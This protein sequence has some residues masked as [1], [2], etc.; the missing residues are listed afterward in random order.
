LGWQCHDAYVTASD[1]VSSSDSAGSS[2]PPRSPDL[3]VGIGNAL[4]GLDPTGASGSGLARTI[5]LGP[6]HP[7][8]HGV[9]RIRLWLD[10]DRITRAEPIVGLLH[11]GA[12]KL[13]EARD[14]RQIM[15]LSNRHDWHG[16]FTSELGVALALEEMLGIDVPV[17][18]TWIRTLLC[19]ITRMLSH[20]LF[21]GAFPWPD[22]DAD[23]PAVTTYAQREALQRVL[24][25]I[26]GGRMHV[27]FACVGGVKA[28]APEGWLSSVVAA[29]DSVRSAMPELA[30]LI[31]DERFV[32]LTRGVGSIT[33]A[34]ALGFGLSGPVAR[35]SGVDLDLRREAPYAAYGELAGSGDLRVVSRAEGDSLARFACLLEEIEVSLG[36]AAAS[37]ARLESIGPGP[38]NVKLPK[39]LKAPEGE[40]Y[41]AVEGPLG[42]NG[43]YLVSRGQKTPWRLKL[44]SASFNNV[45]V[46][47][48]LLVGERVADLETILASLFFVIGDIDK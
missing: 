14:Y 23:T 5:T 21:L 47:E 43:Y 36:L 2:D 45:S 6:Q 8:T 7:S 10:G 44:R 24:E 25:Q 31:A 1:S 20:L 39:V 29:L 12:E 4:L 17:R 13:F 46:L 26:S 22:L 35:A 16:A 27:M 48:E 19:E 38:V 40:T 32:A 30:D 37:V 18:A 41:A 42:T 28:D 11:R 3:I 34:Q 9:L 15:A 33:R